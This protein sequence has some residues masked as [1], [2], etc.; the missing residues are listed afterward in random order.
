LLP[1]VVGRAAEVTNASVTATPAVLATRLSAAMVMDT[2][3]GVVRAMMPLGA[4]AD[5]MVSVSVCTVMPVVEPMVP[6]PMV[7][8]AS[9]M[10]KGVPAGMGAFEMV[11][12]KRLFAVSCV[13]VAVKIAT[14]EVPAR[15]LEGAWAAKN[16]AG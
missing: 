1:A 7:I 12:T 9:V 4:P 6:A 14:D 3:V 2:E 8:P 11:I 5:A 10:V 15:L 16:P 13:D